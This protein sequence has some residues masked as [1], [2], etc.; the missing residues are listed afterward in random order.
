MI[1][2]SKILPN[3]LREAGSKGRPSNAPAPGPPSDG[4]LQPPKTKLDLLLRLHVGK[5]EEELLKLS[6][7]EQVEAI[8]A[9]FP[10]AESDVVIAVLEGTSCDL[11][12][13][14]DALLAMC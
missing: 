6:R 9:M 14:V 8:R 10:W 3:A 1:G 4:N 11:E 5:T 2:G 12:A 7:A 13:A